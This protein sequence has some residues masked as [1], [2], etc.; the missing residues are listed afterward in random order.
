MNETESKDKTI[1]AL[2][3]QV[4]DMAIRVR[5]LENDNI[6]TQEENESVFLKYVE[7]LN[8]WRKKN[9]ELEILKKHLEQRVQERTVQ[10][11]NSNR[12]LSEEIRKYQIAEASRRES[13]ER[14]RTLF[15]NNHTVILLTNPQTGLIVDANPAACQ[16]YNCSREMMR[17]MK[18]THIDA[19]TEVQEFFERNRESQFTSN[20]FYSQHRL[21]DGQVRDVEVYVGPIHIDEKPHLC[22]VIHDITDRKRI[23]EE[24]TR[25]HK[26][27]S[28]GILAGGIAHDFN[29]LLAVI[30]GTITLVKMISKKD[31]QIF[32][33]LSRAEAACIQAREL[34]S[35]LITFSEGGGPLKRI[36]LLDRLLQESASIALSGSNIQSSFEFP[37]NLWPALIDEGQMQQVVLHLVRNAREAMPEGGIVTIRAENIRIMKGENPAL[38]E[39]AYVKWSVEDHGKGIPEEDRSRIFDP[40]FTTKSFGNIKGKGLGLAICHSIIKK[41]EGLI[42][43]STEVGRGTRFT[44]YIPASLEEK[45][46]SRKDD[47]DQK[48]GGAQGRI[49]VMDDEETVRQVMG[50]ILNHLGYEVVTAKNG[51][52]A[53][54]MYREAKMTARPYDLVLLDLTVRGG[55]GGKQAIQKMLEF[56][57]D[58]RA[59]IATGYSND[60]IV[61]SFR[62]YG[63]KEAITKPFTLMTLKSAV[64]DV[65]SR[66]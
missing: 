28:V 18:V 54:A 20:H 55:M 25:V 63:F 62:D 22:S 35:R 52:E 48:P 24:I 10:L 13:E 51:E 66:G 23:D 40:Y 50:Q 9:S 43:Y 27:E 1:Q 12:A 16:Y 34:T 32:N 59:I 57:P 60:P 45:V 47:V 30:M 7:M 15:E 37:E 46:L 58:V 11:E 53:V 29:N 39:G 64:S 26:L 8:E 6:L 3:R 4:E 17:R 61:Q 33:E 42:T 14:Y 41:H 56:D 31:D 19:L 44:V 36:H 49:L 5:H 21:A 2:Q 38:K 65:L